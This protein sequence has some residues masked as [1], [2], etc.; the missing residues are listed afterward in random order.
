MIAITGL[1]QRGVGGFKINLVESWLSR[2]IN[3]KIIKDEDEL[4]LT[5][6]SLDVF[7]EKV[8]REEKG[9]KLYYDFLKPSFHYSGYI[10][11][12]RPG[13][14]QPCLGLILTRVDFIDVK[15]FNKQ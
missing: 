10:R 5:L 9:V 1:Y 4:T 15:S 7:I 2:K 14:G 3:N 11:I 6:K 12:Y 13:S 8:N